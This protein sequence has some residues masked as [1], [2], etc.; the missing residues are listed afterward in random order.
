MEKEIMTADAPFDEGSFSI[1]TLHLDTGGRI[2][3]CPL[4]GLHGH[5]TS[6]LELVRKWKP[7]IV[8]SLTEQSEMD[9]CGS[10]DLKSLLSRDGIDWTHL[11]IRDFGGPTGTSAEAWPELSLRLHSVLDHGAGVFLHCRGGQ[12]RSGM[13]ALRLL[14]E[15]GENAEASLQR[16]RRER[17]G[18]IE[19]EEQF[20]W[21]SEI[22]HGKI[23]PLS[24]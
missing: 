22:N 17:P 13:L 6:D 7:S 9:V 24:E 16:I 14:V 21:A 4:P 18:A 8:L 1:A 12:G 3:V 2:G 5:L 20:A 11:P 10:G 15:R 19:T 23:E